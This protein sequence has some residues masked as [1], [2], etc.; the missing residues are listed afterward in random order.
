[1]KCENLGNKCKCP[2]CGTPLMQKGGRT[3]EAK[4]KATL[5]FTMH[6]ERVYTCP[7]CGYTTKSN[8][9]LMK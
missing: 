8:T 3:G 9:I 4:A 7:K 6:V 5:F 1:M 2:K